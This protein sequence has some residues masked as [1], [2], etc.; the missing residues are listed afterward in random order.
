MVFNG[1]SMEKLVKHPSTL[2]QH[3]REFF[4]FIHPKDSTKKHA[5]VGL[6]LRVVENDCGI[7]VLVAERKTRSFGR[8]LVEWLS[9]ES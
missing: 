4:A 6:R 8:A 7:S 2:P 1:H 9:S 3:S 5:L